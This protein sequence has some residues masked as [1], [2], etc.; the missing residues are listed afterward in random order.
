MFV[1][2]EGRIAENANVQRFNAAYLY[3][4]HS[5]HERNAMGTGYLKDTYTRSPPYVL[6]VT[7]FNTKYDRSE[8]S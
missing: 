4:W 5:S 7:S 8:F 6:P 2:L 3:V 1:C